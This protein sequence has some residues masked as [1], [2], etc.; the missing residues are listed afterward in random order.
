MPS[1]ACTWQPLARIPDIV[2]LFIKAYISARRIDAFLRCENT[3][4]AVVTKPVSAPSP[5]PAA[6]HQRGS[7][8][9]AAAVWEPLPSRFGVRLRDASFSWGATHAATAA[10]LREDKTAATG[11]AGGTAVAAGSGSAAPRKAKRQSKRTAA[12][13]GAT[14]RRSGS[15]DSNAGQY[16]TLADEDEEAAAGAAADEDDGDAD[17]EHGTELAKRKSSY[18][19]LVQIAAVA[20]LSSLLAHRL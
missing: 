11:A 16:S 3:E 15:S 4:A 2:S 18:V 19:S 13:A 7:A 9:A 1:C 12:A 8:A 20:S 6:P 14:A 5:P 17:G 10:V